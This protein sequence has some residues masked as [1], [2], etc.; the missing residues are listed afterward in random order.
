MRKVG[1]IRLFSFGTP[2]SEFREHY[3]FFLKLED[4]RDRRDKNV[5][6]TIA[7][8]HLPS[9]L[10]G[11]KKINWFAKNIHAYKLNL[12]TLRKE[13][14]KISH[15]CCDVFCAVERLGL[16]F[17]KFWRFW[18][19]W[20]PHPGWSLRGDVFLLLA[21]EARSPLGLGSGIPH[22]HLRCDFNNGP[23][24]LQRLLGRLRRTHRLEALGLLEDPRSTSLGLG[25]PLG[26]HSLL[27]AA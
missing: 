8:S 26:L 1:F 15:V 4:R 16:G 5:R 22:S 17:W 18:R 2:S 7:S 12:V 10:L 27:Q 24:I 20:T 6:K 9:L 25:D 19:F 21:P 11:K 13:N 3:E 23:R 14:L